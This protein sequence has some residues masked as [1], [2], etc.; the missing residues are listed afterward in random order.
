MLSG[1]SFASF[2]LTE[3]DAGSDAAAGKTLAVRDGDSY[4]I[5]GMKCFITNGP[6]AD[7]YVVYTLTDPA[8]G[9]KGMAT[10]IVER[11]TPGLTIG[12]IENKMGIRAAQVSE[13]HFKDARV[14]IENMIAAPGKRCC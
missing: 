1:Q 9:T 5:N 7:V 3:P 14:P 13:I 10:F 11:N 2:A 4:V 8:L 6:L 12:K